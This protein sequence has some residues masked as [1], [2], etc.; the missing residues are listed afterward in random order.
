MA[1]GKRLLWKQEGSV[2]AATINGAGANYSAIGSFS[3]PSRQVLISN[4]TDVKVQIGW[5]G[6]QDA[7]PMMPGGQIILDIAS[8]KQNEN[9]LFAGKGDTIYVKALDVGSLPN[10]GD[11]YLSSGYGRGD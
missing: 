8:N 5:V 2:S 10:T 7:F 1:Y 9:S 6:E 3:Y 11:V 4:F